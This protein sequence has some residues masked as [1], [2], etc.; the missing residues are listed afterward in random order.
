[1]TGDYKNSRHIDFQILHV[2]QIFLGIFY[3]LFIFTASVLRFYIAYNTNTGETIE[4]F[5]E[6]PDINLGLLVRRRFSKF[7]DLEL[8]DVCTEKRDTF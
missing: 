8:L 4:L 1:M 7:W 6:R 3:A 5:I 2:N